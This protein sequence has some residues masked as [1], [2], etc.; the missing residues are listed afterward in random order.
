MWGAADWASAR[1]KLDTPPFT[2]QNTWLYSPRIA[3]VSTWSHDMLRMTP[4][5]GCSRISA[6]A[7][8]DASTVPRRST[9][10]RRSSFSV[11]LSRA[12][13]PVRMSAPAL[14]IQTLTRPNARRTPAARTSRSSCRETSART[15]STRRPAARALPAA[16]SAP[17]RFSRKVRARS[18]PASAHASAMARPMPLDAP[19]TSTT[20]PASVGASASRCSRRWVVVTAPSASRFDISGVEA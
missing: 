8:H 6:T 20:L 19:V 5:G 13:S 17:A 1:L 12:P 18:A 10:R 16:S 14:L 4:P 9:A 7:V 15:T 3:P 11:Q 2:A